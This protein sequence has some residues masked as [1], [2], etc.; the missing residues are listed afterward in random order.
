MRAN[1][2]FNLYMLFLKEG[3]YT[4]FVFSRQ[5]KIDFCTTR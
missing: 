5:V 1:S 3:D 2:S 4:V